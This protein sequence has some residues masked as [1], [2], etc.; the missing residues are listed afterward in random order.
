MY[1]H[2]G[3]LAK[4]PVKGALKEGR[5]FVTSGYWGPILL[6]RAD[7]RYEPG[8]TLRVRRGA[9]SIDLDMKV[10]SNRKLKGYD[11]GI[12][13][14]QDGKLA[15]TLPTHEFEGELT[16]AARTS[17][18]VSKDGWVVVQA[19]GDWPSMAM[20]NALYVDVAPY[21]DG[22]SGWQVPAGATG[23]FNPFAEV[24]G[25]TC[26]FNVPAQSVPDQTEV[27]PPIPLPPV[28]RCQYRIFR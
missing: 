15:K 2:S 5:A 4:K 21:D 26:T 18:P 17:V 1:V 25:D 10:L 13:I 20:T 3:R 14:I 7:E 12:R 28:N 19:F 6:V 24:N 16:L 22:P 27:T 11:A 8:D 9:G 23:W